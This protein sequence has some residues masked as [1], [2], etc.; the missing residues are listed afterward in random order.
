MISTV[1]GAV[2]N[3][4]LDPILIFGFKMGIQGAAIATIAGQ[5]V[6]AILC[7]IYF[8]KPKLIK[9]NKE[10]FKIEKK[11]FIKLMQLG[12]SSFITQISIAIITIVANNV[13][14]TIGGENAT[15]AGGALGIVFKVF[16]IVIA[17]S[18]G[19]AVGAQP[20]QLLNNLKKSSKNKNTL[21]V[22]MHDTKDVNDSSQVLKDSIAYLRN[23]GY[24][25]QN[26]YDLLQ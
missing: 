1:I 3:L 8:I 9:L 26:F 19:V 2:I 4:I 14:G 6:S 23:Q 13:V 15:D 18:I 5:I 7:A 17:F 21:V 20:I 22:L 11:V 25:F 24:E 12:I 16:A 10:T